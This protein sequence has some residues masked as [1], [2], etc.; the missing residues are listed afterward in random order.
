MLSP[1]HPV[2]VVR[3][4]QRRLR[5]VLMTHR[6]FSKVRFV[7]CADE[8]AGQIE[9]VCEEVVRDSATLETLVAS[10]AADGVFTPDECDAII[11]KVREI[12]TEAEEG[13]VIR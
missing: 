9:E 5:A 1:S 12:G 11:A 13:R 3:G 10:A 7:D 6:I 2:R 4:C 8:S